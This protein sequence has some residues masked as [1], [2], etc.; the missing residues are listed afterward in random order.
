[1]H[2]LHY[3]MNKVNLIKLTNEEQYLQYIAPLKLKVFS[4]ACLRMRKLYE[5]DNINH[6]N[7]IDKLIMRSNSMF[8]F[9]TNND[10]K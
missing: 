9:T 3:R 5:T 7:M 10:H 2:N 1:M 4:K 6:L 8:E